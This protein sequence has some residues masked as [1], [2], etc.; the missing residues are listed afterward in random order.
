MADVVASQVS[1]RDL[2]TH[3]S[4]WLARAQAGEVVEITSH[5]RPIA[6]ITA[7]RKPDPASSNP[8]ERAIAAGIVSWNGRKPV[9]PPA[10]SLRGEGQRVS[11][12]VIEDRG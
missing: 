6:R 4:Q 8:L 9:F 5:R 12:I 2:K 3:L 1:V 7:V 10:V 11:E